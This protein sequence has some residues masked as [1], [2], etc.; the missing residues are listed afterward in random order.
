MSTLTDFLRKEQENEE[1][2]KENEGQVRDEWLE[3]VDSF[4]HQISEWLSDSISEGFVEIK[5]GQTIPFNEQVTGQYSVK[6]LILKFANGTV[7]IEPKGRL[8]VGAKGRIDIF[9]PVFYMK[10]YIIV[11]QE[12]KETEALTWRLVLDTSP[13]KYEDFDKGVFERIVVELLS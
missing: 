12:D 6:K 7:E 3:T 11:R 5:D 4:Y 8:I 1:R 2:T 9:N 10:K 13:Q